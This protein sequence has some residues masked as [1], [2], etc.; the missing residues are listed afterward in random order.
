MGIRIEPNRFV[1]CAAP[2]VQAR[3]VSGL[4]FSHNDIGPPNI[5]EVVRAE[6]CEKVIAE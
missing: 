1:D 3:S 2:L 6:H 4:T 5:K